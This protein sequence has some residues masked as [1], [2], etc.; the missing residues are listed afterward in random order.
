[1]GAT[2]TKAIDSML[3]PKV[4]SLMSKNLSKWKQMIGRF[5]N[6]RQQSLYDT[7]PSTRILYG[8]QDIDDLYASVGIK[9]PE[10]MD[11]ILRHITILYQT[12]IQERQRILRPYCAYA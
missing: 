10:I 1:M 5:I 11:A 6:K 7:F 8:Q 2:N 12:L 9:E 3:Y 4:S